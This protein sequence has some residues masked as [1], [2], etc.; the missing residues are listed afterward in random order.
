MLRSIVE[1]TRASNLGA[2]AAGD[3]QRRATMGLDVDGE[4]VHGG[5]MNGVTT[6]PATYNCQMEMG[7]LRCPMATVPSSE[8][9]TTVSDSL[10]GATHVVCVECA[11]SLT[12]C[13]RCRRTVETTSWPCLT[14]ATRARSTLIGQTSERECAPPQSTVA[15]VVDVEWMSSDV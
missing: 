8:P 1:N 7:H 13:V 9:L 5:R 6:P 11:L 10:S 15:N 12:T 4:A 14:K 3:K 2:S